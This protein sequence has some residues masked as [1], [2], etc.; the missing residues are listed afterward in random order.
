MKLASARN[1]ES[2]KMVLKDHDAS[3]PDPAYWVFSEIGGAWANVTIISSGNY[4][5]EFVKTF[6]HYHSVSINETYRVIEGE[7][8]LQLQKK[9]FENDN[10]VAERVEEVL[11]ISAKAGDQLV[12]APEYGHSWSNVGNGPLI[13]LDD[14]VSGHTQ[15]D[16]EAISKLHGMSYYLINQN[17]SKFLKNSNYINLPDPKLLS[18]E[19]FN[20]LKQEK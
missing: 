20:Q 15:Q 19:K 3:G 8:V 5:G 10:W 17:G 1:L 18:A 2:L 6:G 11:L 9:F 7:G 16:Y 13:L 14:W 12:I 4:S